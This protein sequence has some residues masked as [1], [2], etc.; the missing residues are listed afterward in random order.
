MNNLT[1]LYINEI[2]DGNITNINDV[3][4]LLRSKVA[5]KLPEYGYTTT[6]DGTIVE[7]A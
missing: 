7:V 2:L 3:P 6:E 5:A 4:K 1:M